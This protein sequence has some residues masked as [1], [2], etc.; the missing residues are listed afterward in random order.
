MRT[1]KELLKE[2]EEVAFEGDGL[3]VTEEEF[4]IIE[5]MKEVISCEYAGYKDG[6]MGEATYHMRLENDPEDIARS[7]YI[8]EE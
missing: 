7:V 5:M 2:L 8:I 4:E 1:E 3:F 6:A